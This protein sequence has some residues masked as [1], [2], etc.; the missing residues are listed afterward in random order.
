[1]TISFEAVQEARFWASERGMVKLAM[2][3]RDLA[4]E[5]QRERMGI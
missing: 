1:M 3:L 5:L 4:R 2:V